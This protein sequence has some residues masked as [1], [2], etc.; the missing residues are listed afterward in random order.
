MNEQVPQ[1]ILTWL[2]QD[3][4]RI[5]ALKALETVAAEFDLQDYWIAAGFIRNL[6]WDKLHHIHFSPLNDVDVIHFAVDKSECFDTQIEQR[7]FQLQSSI[8]W[9]VKNQSRMHIRNGDQPYLS[10]I[11]AMSYWPEKETATAVRLK[12]EQI[13]FCSPFQLSN[14]LKLNLTYNPKRSIELFNQRVESKG[15]LQTYPKLKLVR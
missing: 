12:G 15:W 4:L 14:L 1:S 7:L 8:P 2:R 9:S 3:S 10:S 6:V 5:S 13:E 11:D